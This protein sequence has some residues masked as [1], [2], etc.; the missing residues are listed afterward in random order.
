MSLL[1]ITIN[2]SFSSTTLYNLYGSEAV[3]KTKIPATL[4]E[5][6]DDDALPSHSRAESAQSIQSQTENASTAEAQTATS[7][8]TIQECSH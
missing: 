5:D 8:S 1:S 3:K 4:E 7:P 2:G 6:S